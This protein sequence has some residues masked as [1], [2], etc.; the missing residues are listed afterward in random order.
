MIMIKVASRVASQK[1][2]F[3]RVC[4]SERVVFLV[5]LFLRNE[6]DASFESDYELTVCSIRLIKTRL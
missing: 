4:A 2:P 5:L 1:D 3:Q 6:K